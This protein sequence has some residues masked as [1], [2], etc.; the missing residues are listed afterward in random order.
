[1]CQENLYKNLG[2]NESKKAV[3][4]KNLFRLLGGTEEEWSKLVKT[5]YNNPNKY[6]LLI[7]KIEENKSRYK[8]N[9]LEKLWNELKEDI[10]KEIIEYLKNRKIDIPKNTEIKYNNNSKFKKWP[11]AIPVFNVQKKLTGI[12]L[13]AINNQVKPK[14]I[15]YPG[16]TLGF[17]GL[18][19][20]K[21]SNL[22]IVVEGSIDF[23]T[24]KS[25]GFKRVIGIT[26]SSQNIPE[27]I[28]Q[29]M[30]K[31]TI[32]FVHNDKAGINLYKKVKEVC[33][34]KNIKLIGIKTCRKEK[35]DLNDFITK[36]QNSKVILKN[37]LTKLIKKESKNHDRNE[38]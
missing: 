26:S 10:P 19:S 25:L 22:T 33:K 5:T 18:D 6:K 8:K 34:S 2:K 27:E 3:S 29:F 14:N 16:S 12:Q 15:M 4:S 38:N 11:I 35:G 7:K 20:L 32:F 21:K 13:R 23:L 24:A 37:Y 30:T 1:M 17:F 31:T 28:T 36:H 9:N